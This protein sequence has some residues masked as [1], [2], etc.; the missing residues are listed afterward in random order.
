MH[1]R[2]FGKINFKFHVTLRSLIGLFNWFIKSG[3][4]AKT[5]QNVAGGN[6]T[7]SFAARK[8]PRGKEVMAAPPPLARSRIPPATQATR[9]IEGRDRLPGW[10]DMRESPKRLIKLTCVYLR[11]RLARALLLFLRYNTTRI[12][13]ICDNIYV[14]IYENGAKKL[15]SSPERAFFSRQKLS[16]K[17]TI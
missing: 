7:G 14:W 17:S 15:N 9:S 12:H 13:E 6:F 2:P 3:R 8:F 16:S 11:L 1:L 4:Q 5:I 10:N